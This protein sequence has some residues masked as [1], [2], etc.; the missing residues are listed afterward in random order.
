MARMA[1]V[2]VCPPGEH[3]RRRVGHPARGLCVGW[4][5]SLA[6]GWFV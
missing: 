3:R 4:N 2:S 5:S 1:A 6:F